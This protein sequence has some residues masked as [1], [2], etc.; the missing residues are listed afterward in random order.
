MTN[1]E[2]M[3]HMREKTPLD[4]V[5]RV[6]AGQCGKIEQACEQRQPLLFYPGAR[7]GI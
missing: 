2:T 5:R 1:E 7:H 3:K 4:Q 6:F